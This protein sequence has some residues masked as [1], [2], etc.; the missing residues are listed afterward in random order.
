MP[1][2]NEIN[3]YMRGLWL[4]VKGDAQGFRLL[5]LTDRGMMRSFWA[6]AW[7]L[8]AMVISWI[9]WRAMYVAGLPE[10]GHVG[11]VFFARLGMLE[12]LDWMVPLVFLG[13]LCVVMDLGKKF[14]PI[15]VTF[16]WL[17]VPFA[18]AYAILSV[19]YLLNIRL[20]GLLAIVHFCILVASIVVLSRLLKMVC[21]PQ[22]LIVTAMIL[23]LIVPDMVLSQF[24]QR[25]LGVY[26]IF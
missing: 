4:L 8:P 14:A 3:L 10:G 15:V 2:Y 12:I 6:F 16:N 13:V 17:S 23:V 9:W 5:D 18:Y 25:F 20:G 22:P 7:C 19:F 24:M 1:P 21:G 26:P 11:G